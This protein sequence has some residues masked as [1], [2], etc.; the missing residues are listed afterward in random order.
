MPAVGEKI[1]KQLC[2]NHFR[3]KKSS[4][5]S[6]VWECSATLC[7]LH[8]AYY[9]SGRGV[10]S[11]S[12][13]LY[14]LNSVKNSPLVADRYTTRGEIFHF[15]RFWTPKIDP[16]PN[17]LKLRFW[18]FQNILRLDFFENFPKSE[19]FPPCFRSVHN[20]GGIFQRGDFSPNWVDGIRAKKTLFLHGTAKHL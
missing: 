3:L 11:A 14:Q 15:L 20:K 12:Y 2:C 8:Y 16:H 7:S 4:L 10:P 1:Q 18:A 6:I 17:C 9:C 5:H 13:S 19:R